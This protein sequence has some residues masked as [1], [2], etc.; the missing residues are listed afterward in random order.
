M[1]ETETRFLLDTEVQHYDRPTLRL[2]VRP[3]Y[4][5]ADDGRLRNYIDS[6]GKEPLADLTINAQADYVSDDAYGWRVEYKQP[7]SVTLRDAETMVKLLRKIDK[8]LAK[9]DA[10]LGRAESFGAYVARVAIVLGV[11]HFGKK[12]DANHDYDGTGYR[13]LGAENF[14]YHVETVVS[15]FKKTDVR[16]GVAG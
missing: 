3:V 7:Y 15:D 12:V 1:A 9:L 2:T 13:W 14:I 6:F 8:G 5:D 11:E 10:K 4:I 16:E